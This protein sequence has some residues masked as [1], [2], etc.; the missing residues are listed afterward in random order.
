MFVET[1]CFELLRP[2]TVSTVTPNT[3][4]LRT[5]LSLKQTFTV[6][7]LFHHCEQ[8]WLL[9]VRFQRYWYLSNQGNS[10]VKRVLDVCFI[11]H[12]MLEAYHNAITPLAGAQPN[13]VR[14]RAANS[15]YT[16]AMISF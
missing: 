13:E 6:G 10:N 15:G 12:N 16:R 5:K 8:S 2:G 7:Q 1:L 14:Q 9:T 4:L 3:R 11:K